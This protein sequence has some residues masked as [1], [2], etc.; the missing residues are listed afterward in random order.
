MVAHE[1]RTRGGGGGRGWAV[2]PLGT[3]LTNSSEET[4]I[5][6]TELQNKQCRVNWSD[7]FLPV[8]SEHTF[9]PIFSGNFCLFSSWQ[10]NLKDFCT[11]LFYLTHNRWKMT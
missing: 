9:S 4:D 2:R 1:S 11:L 10:I 6:G 5:Q 3:R 7:G 8:D